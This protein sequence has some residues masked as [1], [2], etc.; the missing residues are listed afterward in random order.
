[1]SCTLSLVL[2]SL[3]FVFTE[4]ICLRSLSPSKKVSFVFLLS[5]RLFATTCDLAG[6]KPLINVSGGSNLMDNIVFL[7]INNYNWSCLTNILQVFCDQALIK[8]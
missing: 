5:L 3:C 4:S 6:N 7:L 1:M 8:R 2:Y